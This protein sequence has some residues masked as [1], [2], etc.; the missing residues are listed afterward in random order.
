ML[1]IIH[2]S[3]NIVFINSG[4]LIDHSMQDYQFAALAQLAE[5]PLSKRKV[6]GSNPTGGLVFYIN[7][8][9]LIILNKSI[10]NNFNKMGTKVSIK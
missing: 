4:L 5:H 6:V 1:S 2:L 9:F 7:Y 8:N 10:N 3:L